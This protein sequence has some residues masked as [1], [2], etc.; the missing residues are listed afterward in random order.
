MIDIL[1]NLSLSVPDLLILLGCAVVSGLLGV[2]IAKLAHR[3]WWSRVVNDG[4][5]SRNMG[6]GVHNSILA[7]IAFLLA[8]ITTSELTS[9]GNAD[10]QVTLEALAIKRVDRDLSR[11]E[12]D[13]AQ[14]RRLL[15]AYVASVAAD[16]W[17]RLA[18]RPQSLSPIAENELNALWA[19]V[20]RLQALLRNDNPNLGYDL[21]DY[22]HKIE[23]AR[24]SRLSASVNGIPD[25][26]WL[27]IG[28]FFLSACVLAGR[29][30]VTRYGAQVVFIQMSALGVILAL[31]IIIDNPFGGDTSLG[32]KRII[33]AISGDV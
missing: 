5:P 15:R 13:G 20:R 30:G 26:V 27:M 7:L 10:H 24:T 9:F 33:G 2:A 14:G 3:L 11:L 28:M 25:V 23:D 17:P 22:M 1:Y 4:E 29:H 6:D 12:A 21:S 32:P 8:L 31:N 16:E 18:R 19:E